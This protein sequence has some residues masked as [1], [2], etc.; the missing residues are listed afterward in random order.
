MFTQGV[1]LQSSFMIE[2]VSLT[3]PKAWPVFGCRQSEKYPGWFGI[4]HS[5]I[6][7]NVDIL[8]FCLPVKARLS[9]V[10]GVG[11]EGR[12]RVRRWGR[13]QENPMAKS[14]PA[15]ALAASGCAQAQC[16]GESPVLGKR[17]TAWLGWRYLRYRPGSRDGALCC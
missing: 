1:N 12:L 5:N 16:R 13:Q 3:G 15:G 2:G 11:I 4:L 7:G 14:F 10:H 8:R 6:H 17:P 9:C